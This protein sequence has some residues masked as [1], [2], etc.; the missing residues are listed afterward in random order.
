MGKN[1]KGVGEMQS[2][3]GLAGGRSVFQL[4]NESAQPRLLGSCDNQE[5][6]PDALG[7]APAD[8]GILNPKRNRLSRD[9]QKQCQL[10][11]GEWRDHAFDTT[12]FC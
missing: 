12:A 1:T 2:V 6:N 8:R 5:F 11:S 10:H 4:L 3:G 9:M 7:P